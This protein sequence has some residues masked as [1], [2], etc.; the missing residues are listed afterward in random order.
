[1]R[2]VWTLNSSF[3]FNFPN[4]CNPRHG[5]I[6]LDFL[7]CTVCFK[8]SLATFWKF[9]ITS[10]SSPDGCFLKIKKLKL[11]NFMFPEK[12]CRHTGDATPIDTHWKFPMEAFMALEFGGATGHGEE[13]LVDVSV[14]SPQTT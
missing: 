7:P 5:I 14:L 9:E 2:V 6:G 8:P 3:H 13:A 12:L 10:L 1:M 4:P 11:K